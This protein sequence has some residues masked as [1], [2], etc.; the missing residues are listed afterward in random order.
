MIKDGGVQG[1]GGFEELVREN[2]DF[3]EMERLAVGS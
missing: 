1:E 2:E 3:A